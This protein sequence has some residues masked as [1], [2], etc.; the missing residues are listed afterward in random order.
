MVGYFIIKLS[1][2]QYIDYSDPV[3]QKALAQSAKILRV[4]YPDINLCFSDELHEDGWFGWDKRVPPALQD[5]VYWY[6]IKRNPEGN[7]PI[8]SPYLADILGSDTVQTYEYDAIVKFTEPFCNMIA[9]QVEFQ[10]ILQLQ[11]DINTTMIQT[12]LFKYNQ[13]GEIYEMDHN[14]YQNEFPNIPIS[15]IKN[16]K[17]EKVEEK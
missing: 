3:D 16:G 12:Y 10:P 5:T 9:C 2:Y 8:F 7:P 11:S 17:K 4:L 14:S 13:N 1:G 6:W 15:L